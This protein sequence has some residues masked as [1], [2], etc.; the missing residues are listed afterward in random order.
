METNSKMTPEN[1]YIRSVLTA[2]RKQIPDPVLLVDS[3]LEQLDDLK[4]FVVGNAANRNE[5]HYDLLALWGRLRRVRP[6]LIDRLGGAAVLAW[7]ESVVKQLPA[8]D[9][10]AALS[11]ADMKA[12]TGEAEKLDAAGEEWI[13]AA[14]RAAWTEAV[15]SDL[16]DADLALCLAEEREIVDAELFQGLAT[17]NAWVSDH[18]E[19]F[20]SAAVWLQAVGQAMRPDLAEYDVGLALTAEKFVRLLDAAEDAEAEGAYADVEPR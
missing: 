11:V 6:A 14:D 3:W 5:L 4:D 9:L 13:E 12:W 20:L 17:G 16:D 7:A 15:L 8:N 1:R 2:T 18:A 19:L 10:R